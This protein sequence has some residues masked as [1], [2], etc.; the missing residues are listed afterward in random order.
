MILF[1][2]FSYSDIYHHISKQQFLFLV[3]L[4]LQRVSIAFQMEDE[5][6]YTLILLLFPFSFI[7]L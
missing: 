7:S 5:K 3:S 4:R 1:L 6:F 2:F